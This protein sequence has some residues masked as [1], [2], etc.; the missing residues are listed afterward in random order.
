MTDQREKMRE[1]L[2]L[3]AAED[4]RQSKLHELLET[5]REQIR[6]EVEPEHRPDGL[7]GNIQNAVYAMRGRTPLMN[8]A[9]ITSALSA[10]ETK[11]DGEARP[12]YAV[13]T[14]C[15]TGAIAGDGG[16]CG[17]CDPCMGEAKVPDAVKRLIAEK[18]SLIH[19]VG[20]L[21]DAAQPAPTAGLE[22]V[23]WQ[24]SW[25]QDGQKLRSA[26]VI[27]DNSRRAAKNI[28]A[29]YVGA[30]DVSVAPLYTAAQV[31]DAVAKEREAL[32]P[33]IADVEQALIDAA[34]YF[35]NRADVN[36]GD[37]GV[38]EP[39]TAMRLVSQCNEA[40]NKIYAIRARGRSE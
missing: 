5:I 26:H 32:L 8:D 24:V 18:N 30:S 28:A 10:G 20:E 38:P 39:N 13:P 34:D 17:D 2:R 22:P 23:A 27:E 33:A 9:A 1:A 21:E 31:A 12:V 40:V 25:T 11:S 35:D 37:Y 36:D 4:D 16:A 6:L 19:R 3:L 15:V 7:F 29:Y 14:C